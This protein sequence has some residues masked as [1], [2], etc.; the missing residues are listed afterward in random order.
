MQAW[1]IPVLKYQV[2]D[3]S[4]LRLMAN[5]NDVLAELMERRGSSSATRLPDLSDEIRTARSTDEVG[6]ALDQRMKGCWHWYS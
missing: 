3:M 2:T 4:Q 5:A 1:N 6:L